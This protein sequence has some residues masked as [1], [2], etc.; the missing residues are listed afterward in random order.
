MGHTAP[1]TT[2]GPGAWMQAAILPYP[3]QGAKDTPEGQ[4]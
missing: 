4:G 2:G 3:G 1:E